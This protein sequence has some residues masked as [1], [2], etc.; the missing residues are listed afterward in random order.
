MPA[1]ANNTRHAVLALGSNLGDRLSN[2]QGAIDA[3]T[4]APGLRLVAVSPVYETDPVGGPEQGEFLNAVIIVDTDLS[5]RMLLERALNVEDAF[6]R[7]REIRWGPRT[8][9]I[10]II[11]VGDETSDED[12]LRVPH[13]R[14]HERPFVLAPWYDI[15]PDGSLHGHGPIGGLLEA[16]G[17]AGVR[18]RDDL[19]LQVPD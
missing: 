18:R 6:G 19:L 8:L 14:A 10:D 11:D 1:P 4:D 12:D 3:L 5:L 9:D 2:L 16:A 15:D 7:V 13:P 17:H